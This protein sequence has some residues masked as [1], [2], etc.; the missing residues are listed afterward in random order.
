VSTSTSIS[1]AERGSRTVLVLYNCDYDEE[2][3]SVEGVDESAV[4]L[5]AAAVVEAVRGYGFQSELIA[6]QGTDIIDVLTDVQRQEPD[7]VFNLCE[8]L[9]GD[10][11]NEVVVPAVL[12]MLRLPYTGSGPLCLGMCLHKERCKEV[13]TARGIATPGYRILHSAADVDALAA[14]DLRFPLFLKLAHEDASIGIEES[15]VCAD[16][17]AVRVRAA[18]ML[19]RYRMPLVC[20]EFIAGREV[21]VTLLGNGDELRVLP[22]YEIDFRDMPDDRPNII[23]YAAKWDESHVDYEG[24]KP[25]PMKGVTPELAAA[26]ES[27]ARAAFEAMGLADFGRVDLRIDADGTPWVIDVNPNCDLSDDAGF[28]RSARAGG[29]DYPDLIGRICEV[30]WNRHARTPQPRID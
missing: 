20:E 11:R 22:L 4:K 8:S 2:L 12:D 17:D 27:T 23:S 6:V 19:E 7:L 1:P 29:L 16:V 24:T 13:L 28:A 21:N 9:N 26:I 10:A 5:A 15:N 3:T 30:A 14:A 25:V 18:A